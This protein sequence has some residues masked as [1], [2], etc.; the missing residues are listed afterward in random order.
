MSVIV[1]L[2]FL[3][4]V[5]WTKP[6]KLLRLTKSEP[7]AKNFITIDENFSS[8]RWIM[9][10]LILYFVLSCLALTKFLTQIGVYDKIFKIFIIDHLILQI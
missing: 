4:H 8:I 6:L 9:L 10:Y 7:K 1:I 3:K 2:I 5:N